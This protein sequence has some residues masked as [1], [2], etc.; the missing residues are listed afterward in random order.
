MSTKSRAVRPKAA[1][2]EW[3]HALKKYER[4]SLHRAIWQLVST[5]VLYFFL[6]FLMIRTIQLGYSYW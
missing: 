4:P 1:R 5:L 3:V 2:P 6:W